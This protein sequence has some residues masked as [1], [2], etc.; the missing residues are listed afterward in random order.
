VLIVIFSSVECQK[1][2]KGGKPDKD[3][4]NTERCGKNEVFD[5]LND[6]CAIP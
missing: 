3:D 5:P 2:G 1:N 4:S 6:V